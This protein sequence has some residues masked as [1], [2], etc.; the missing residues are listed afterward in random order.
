MRRVLAAFIGARGRVHPTGQQQLRP[1]P[2]GDGQAGLQAYPKKSP[3]GPRHHRDGGRRRGRLGSGKA[4][5]EGGRRRGDNRGGHEPDNRGDERDVHRLSR[6]RRGHA[7]DRAD[8]GGRERE[9]ALRQRVA[10]VRDHSRQRHR[11]DLHGGDARRRRR[12]GRQR[13]HGDGEGQDRLHGGDGGVGGDG[14][15]ERQRGAVRQDAVHHEQ[16]RRGRLL[17]GGRY[18]PG[19]GQVS[20]IR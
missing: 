14:N 18:H 2:G 6:G 16:P 7:P 15:G 3:P 4:D 13:H 19:H 8:G 5:G 11:R 9:H 17:L 12:R 10:E 1:D 20:A